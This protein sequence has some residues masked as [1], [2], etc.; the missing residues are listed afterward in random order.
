MGVLEGKVAVIVGASSGFG[1]ALARHF[2]QQGARLVIAARR[3]ALLDELAAP[4]QALPVACDVTRDGEVAALAQ[5]AVD[6]HGRIDIAINS[7][8]YE[9]QCLIRD[10]TPDKLE[11]M[12]SV[13]F[14]A[15]VYFIRHM[16]N[17]MSETGGG[18]IVTMSSLTASMVPESYA[19]YAGAKAGINQVTRIAALEY[20]RAG[21]RVNCVSPSV[22][23][24]PM[25]EHLLAVDGVRK[26]FIENTP[27]GRIGDMQDVLDMTTF[28]ASDQARYITGQIL[29]VDGGTSLMRLPT[30]DDVMRH[31]G[32]GKDRPKAAAAAP[33]RKPFHTYRLPADSQDAR[34]SGEIDVSA[35]R[36]WELINDF[37]NVDWVPGVQRT[38]LVGQG[39]GTVRKIYTGTGELPPLQEILE[40]S[41]ASTRTLRY[42]VGAGNPLPVRDYHAQMRVVALGGDRCRLDWSSQFVPTEGDVEAACVSVEGIYE[43]AF[44]NIKQMLEGTVQQPTGSRSK[45]GLPDELALREVFLEH[46]AASLNDKASQLTEQLGKT[47]MFSLSGKEAAD[48]TVYFQEDGI[49]VREGNPGEPTATIALDSDNYRDMINGKLDGANMYMGGQLKIEG[50]LGLAM[51]LQTLM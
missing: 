12:V 50:D 11:A 6:H 31:M 41:D 2:H 20:G 19:A 23:E 44:A 18:S 16:A 46:M 36:A 7:A 1:E 47:L 39:P 3:K 14:T 30:Q 26:A 34:L 49:V 9:E 27:L 33:Q 40:S 13:Q 48:Y 43:L 21:V 35:D 42:E 22:I 29:L 28:V 5:A 4:L 32:M 38:E 25:T 51:K 37:G 17:A 15:G 24:T 10:L 8:G 45:A